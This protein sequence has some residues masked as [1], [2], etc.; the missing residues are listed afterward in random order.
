MVLSQ[1]Q[2]DELNRAI[3]EYLRSNGYEEAYSTFKKEAELDMQSA[4]C[5]RLATLEFPDTLRSSTPAAAAAAAVAATVV[6]AAPALAPD[7]VPGSTSTPSWSRVVKGQKK[8]SLPLYDT[9]GP[10]ENDV[11]LAN[12]FSPLAN[13]PSKPVSPSS[14]RSVARTR[15]RSLPLSGSSPSDY[16]RSTND[17]VS[18]PCG[19]YGVLRWCLL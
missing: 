7:D 2:R 18:L 15:K 17:P 9:F 5:S 16:K 4:L 14:V 1:R 3:A 8:F 11:T 6:A 13:L 19:P 12:F 10:G